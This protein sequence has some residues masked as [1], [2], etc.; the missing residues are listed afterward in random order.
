MQLFFLVTAGKITIFQSNNFVRRSFF[1]RAKLPVGCVQCC[2]YDIY[3]YY[4]FTLTKH[5]TRINIL[6]A[7]HSSSCFVVYL[8]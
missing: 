5:I 3:L 7:S 2:D 1:S 8:R 6:N 4:R